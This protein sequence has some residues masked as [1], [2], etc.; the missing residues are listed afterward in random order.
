[1]VFM[2]VG[3]PTVM[4][5]EH[6]E[7]SELEEVNATLGES[8]SVAIDSS[9]VDLESQID[10]RAFEA[11]LNRAES[12]EERVEIA[13]AQLEQLENEVD[14]INNSYSNATESERSGAKA[15]QIAQNAN[16]ADKVNNQLNE[17]E[18]VFNNVNENALENASV[19]KID[20]LR[21]EL[22]VSGS[23]SASVVRDS[24]LSNGLKVGLNANQDGI[25]VASYV[26]DERVYEGME[27]RSEAHR[28]FNI[29]STEA[30][31]IA[32][33]KI[34]DE[35]AEIVSVTE[36][37]RGAY[38]VEFVDDTESITTI[39]VDSR[40][41]EV[42]KSSK[43]SNIPEH[44]LDRIPSFV[45]NDD[46]KMGGPPQHAEERGPPSWVGNNNGSDN[47]DRNGA[48]RNGA[49]R[50]G[51]DRNGPDNTNDEEETTDDEGESV[52][53]ENEEET[54]DDEG[55]SVEEENEEETTE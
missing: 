28:E 5:E 20:D 12:D 53:E 55:E 37:K 36:L 30:E 16:K 8:L 49:D 44:A 43:R 1:M 26:N 42:V 17:I 34:D 50:N 41:G 29:N 23:E 18:N 7:E 21:S 2:F 46:G 10:K 6:N 15:S 3:A 4:A 45:F 24:M 19:D 38:E 31:N 22:S 54:T 33:S 25:D 48:D 11:M 13:L 32:S 52:E 9:A 51:A 47:A 27:R 14:E 39:T 40:D 35:S